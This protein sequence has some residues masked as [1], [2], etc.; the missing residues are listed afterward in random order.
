[1]GCRGEDREAGLYRGAAAMRW[2][3]ATGAWARTI[4][5]VKEGRMPH[6]LMEAIERRYACREF[7][8]DR[9]LSADQLAVLL[10]AARLAPSGFGLEPWRFVAVTDAAGRER[11]A[12]A[13]FGQPA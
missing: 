5:K 10:E 12:R 9:P 8:A 3:L 11:V 7:M 1:M 13:C 2:G 4:L 6:A